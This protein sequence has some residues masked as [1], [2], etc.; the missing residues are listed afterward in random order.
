MFADGVRKLWIGRNWKAERDGGVGMVGGLVDWWG[1]RA[2]TAA[3]GEEAMPS[4]LT[5][6]MQGAALVRRYSVDAR[7]GR[8]DRER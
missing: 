5:R 6:W 2:R 3:E 8:V 1:H 7:S 4:I